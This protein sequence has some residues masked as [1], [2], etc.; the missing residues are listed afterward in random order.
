[1]VRK[2]M[3]DRFQLK[4]HY[5]KRELPVY[6]L[7]VAKG[8]PKLKKGDPNEPAGLGGGPGNLGATNATMAD[9]AELLAHGFLDRPVID[10]TGLAGKFDLRLTWTPDEMQAATQSADAPPGLF[11]A[12]QEQL[13]L[14]LVS[15]K[16]PADVI[17]IDHVEKPSAN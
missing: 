11:T 7:T 10:Q 9:L 12:I 6:L 2:L 17:V 14:K 4:F 8:G 5:E 3:A 16:A 15:T 13:G 1:M